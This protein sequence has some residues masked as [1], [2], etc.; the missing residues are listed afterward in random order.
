MKYT[1]NDTIDKYEVNLFIDFFFSCRVL[2]NVTWN[3]GHSGMWWGTGAQNV[4]LVGTG[5][6]RVGFIVFG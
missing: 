2:I 1:T 6:L 4:A 3:V 5:A